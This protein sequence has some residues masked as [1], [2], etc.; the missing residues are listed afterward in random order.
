MATVA[1][2]ISLLAGGENY[3]GRPRNITEAL[4]GATNK[5]RICWRAN[6]MLDDA[7]KIYIY[8]VIAV[9]AV[10]FVL[11]RRQLASHI[12]DPNKN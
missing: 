5:E 2:Y 1:I 8:V 4:N 11:K 6:T 3:S 10:S 9:A 7:E 12:S